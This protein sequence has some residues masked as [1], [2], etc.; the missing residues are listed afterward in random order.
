M[1]LIMFGN[2]PVPYTASWSSEERFTLDRCRYAD[3]RVAICQPESPGTGQ[4][5]FGKPHAV[6]QRKTM[7]LCL[8]DLCGRPLNTSTKVSL[9]HA[10]PQ[11]HG[12][13]GWAILQVEPLLHRDCAAMCIRYCPS[14]RRDL[15][16]GTLM[17][18]RVTRHRVQYAIMDRDYVR[19]VTGQDRTAVGHAKVELLAWV[20]HDV[21]WLT[22]QPAQPRN[23]A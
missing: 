4:P 6:R 5:L 12:A 23:T 2:T 3:N 21:A 19:P 7:T 1:T 17:I 15:A 22:R 11:P 16:A 9:S 20:D 13:E 14:L 8:C 10:R 18:R